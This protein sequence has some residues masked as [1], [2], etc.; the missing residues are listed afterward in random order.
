MMGVLKLASNR[1]FSVQDSMCH[2][3]EPVVAVQRALNHEVEDMGSSPDPG[4]FSHRDSVPSPVIG[5]FILDD[6]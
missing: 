3:G 5:R 1:S 2:E 6:L 4:L